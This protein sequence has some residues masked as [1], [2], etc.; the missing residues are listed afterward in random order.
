MAKSNWVETLLSPAQ[1]QSVSDAVSRAEK[2]TSGEIV[3]MIVRRS[4]AIGHVRIILVLLWLLVIAT[5]DILGTTFASELSTWFY[6]KFALDFAHVLTW[7]TGF[8]AL[9]AIPVA[10]Y[11]S[12]CAGVQRRLTPSVDLDAE[13]IGRAQLEFYWANLQNT[14]GRTGI[15]IFLSHMERKCVVLADEG[16]SKLLPKETWDDVVKT[17][18]GGIRANKASEGISKAVEMCGA[19]LAKHCP[20]TG[21]NPNELPNQLIVKE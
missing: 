9:L 11:F 21:A 8:G 3:P 4:S 7:A 18:V 5:I 17:V 20:P 12:A 6:E 15:L 16:I 2:S 13:V 14:V 19:I 1:I 10:Y